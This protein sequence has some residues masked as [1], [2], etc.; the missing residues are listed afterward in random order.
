MSS[1]TT[2]P[3]QEK[4][5][6]LISIS[7][8]LPISTSLI[9]VVP[10]T[11]CNRDITSI[12]SVL[13]G[14]ILISDVSSEVERSFPHLRDEW[15]LKLKESNYSQFCKKST[16]LP[17]YPSPVFANTLYLTNLRLTALPNVSLMEQSFHRS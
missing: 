10:S 16:L 9:R 14:L 5:S 3:I 7:T 12:Y 15:Y 17:F 11:I 1:L 6:Q 13:Y 2:K 4:G 8:Y